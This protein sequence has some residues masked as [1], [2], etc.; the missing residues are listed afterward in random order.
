MTAAQ[1]QP[2]LATDSDAVVIGSDALF[3]IFS[4]ERP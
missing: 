1:I 3:I 2:D 4:S